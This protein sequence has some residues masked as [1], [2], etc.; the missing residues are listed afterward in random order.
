MRISDWSSDVCPTDVL[1]DQR[2]AVI[3]CCADAADH[4]DGGG[5]V[6]CQR[7][8]GADRHDRIQYRAL[9][10]GQHV[11]PGQRQWRA[12]IAAATDERSEEHTSAQSLMRIT[13]AVFC[14][15]KKTK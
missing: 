13:Y 8:A 14:L 15:K 12:R 2:G 5:L 3:T 1:V 6:R 9:A 10:A 4:V 11:G 7:D